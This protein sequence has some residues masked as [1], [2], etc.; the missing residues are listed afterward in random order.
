MPSGPVKHSQARFRMLM[1][2]CFCYQRRLAQVFFGLI[3]FVTLMI[4]AAALWLFTHQDFLQQQVIAGLEASLGQ[5]AAV[6]DVAIIFTPRPVVVLHNLESQGALGSFS[7]PKV[8]FAPSLTSLLLARLEPAYLQ[9]TSPRINL[10][11]L[12]KASSHGSIDPPELPRGCTLVIENGSFR[13]A[14]AEHALMAE[15]IDCYLKIRSGNELQGDLFV[16]S[17]QFAVANQS[18]CVEDFLFLGHIA[19][20]DFER[21]DSRFDLKAMLRGPS[22]L[23]SMGVQ[24]TVGKKNGL[25]ECASDIRAVFLQDDFP[26]PF[27]LKGLTKLTENKQTLHFESMALSLGFRDSGTFNGTYDSVRQSLDGRLHINHVSLTEWLGFARNLPAGLMR[28]LDHVTNAELDFHIDAQGLSVPKVSA[29]CAGSEFSGQGGVKDWRKPV[30]FLDMQAPFVDLIRAIPEAGAI[31]PH[32]PVYGHAAL[33]PEGD[34]SDDEPSSVGYDIRLGAAS[35]AYGPLRIDHARVN[36][37]PAGTKA[38]FSAI[39]PSPSTQ[40][41]GKKKLSQDILVDARAGFYDGQFLG[42]LAL[43]GERDVRYAIKASF[44]DVNGQKLGR[45]MPVIPVRKGK[46]QAQAQVLSQ[47]KVLET[48]LQQ[49]RG[50]VRVDCRHGELHTPGSAKNLTFTALHGKLEPLRQGQWKSEKLFLDGLWKIELERNA[51][52]VNMQLGGKIGFGVTSDGSGVEFQNLESKFSVQQGQGKE[53][54]YWGEARLFW[55]PE[56]S[57][58]RAQNSQITCKAGQFTG[59]AELALGREAFLT[60]KGEF[61]ISDLGQLI[62]IVS[63]NSPNIPAFLRKL[64]GQTSFE[65][66]ANSLRFTNLVCQ[67]DLGPLHGAFGFDWSKKFT[68]LPELVLDNLATDKL[69]GTT[70]PKQGKS[71]PLDYQGIERLRILGSLVIKD[72]LFKGIHFFDVRLP[73]DLADAVCS[74]KGISGLLYQGRLNGQATLVFS[75]KSIE[76]QSNGELSGV[77]LAALARDAMRDAQMTGQAM[78]SGTI[79]AAFTS[80]SDWPGCLWGEWSFLAKDGSYQAM[81]SYARPHA[82]PT[83]FSTLS[84]KGT[85]NQGVLQSK[86]VQFLG[87]GLKLTGKGELDLNKQSIDCTFEVD[88][89]GMPYFPIYIEGTLDKTKTSIGAGQLILNALGGIFGA[90]F[91]I[92]R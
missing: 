29:S 23:H 78:L 4:M 61:S 2:H 42:C 40:P 47:G 38:S 20:F 48:F 12:P 45:A 90:F 50:Q 85:I 26:L 32:S 30:V 71:A 44:S 81:K 68:L 28:S 35:V 9:C 46:W 79:R 65:V 14:S 21:S 54:K 6:D 77:S 17:M 39:E 11:E 53:P 43:G 88:K 8:V 5:K 37:H 36:I 59:Q 76:L 84:A 74:L 80:F 63:Q 31:L 86:D 91:G 49:L 55:L 16:R 57:Q 73:I 92:F 87:D 69:M 1:S 51:M 22:W 41:Q 24:A 25:W 83:S 75:H 62:S 58:L 60:G 72:L 66:K 56:K 13:L 18:L 10:A 34:P 7:I 67:T 70:K 33:T 27:S 82:K 3:V 89:K 64:K 15:G 19:P 52:T